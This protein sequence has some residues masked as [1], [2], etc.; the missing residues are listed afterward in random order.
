MNL[1]TYLQKKYRPK[2][3]KS[4]MRS[5]EIF[6][7]SNQNAKKYYHADIVNYIGSLRI[8][9][10]SARTL[11]SILSAIKTYY[12]YLAYT[13]IRNDNPA[14]SIK[15]RGQPTRDIQLQDL[16][17]WEELETLL[18]KKERFNAL[19]YRNKVLMSLLIYQGLLP[20]EITRLNV[21]DINLQEGT[22]YIKPGHN[23]NARELTLK[24]KQVLLFYQYIHEIRSKLSRKKKVSDDEKA[25][26]IG[27]RNNR[28]DEENIV[29]HL[30]RNYKGVFAPRRVNCQTIRQSVITNLLK[31]GHDVTIVQ[32]FAGHKT[33]GTTQKYKQN[34]VEELQQALSKYHPFA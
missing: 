20:R 13:G 22:I 30:K 25:L 1:E 3:V 8:K 5:I 14:R 2:S 33:P 15:L 16:F 27:V 4:Y 21:E 31:Q 24:P 29:T 7:S 32:T 17:T 34:D 12:A 10:Q 11:A 26:I 9:Y 19:E 18:N 28:F 6:L 23:T